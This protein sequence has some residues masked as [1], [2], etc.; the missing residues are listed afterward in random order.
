MSTCRFSAV[1]FDS[2]SGRRLG[3]ITFKWNGSAY[4]Y[5][6]GIGWY[7]SLGGGTCET[8]SGELIS[9]A[10]T[11]HELVRVS[12]SSATGPVT[13]M[14]GTKTI[15]GTPT[16]AGSAAGCAP[17]SITFNVVMASS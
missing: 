5:A 17:Y 7:R 4:T 1:T 14:S 12:P 11:V 15:S 3:T 13:S 8:S 10:Y 9:N 6:G 2:S 16:D